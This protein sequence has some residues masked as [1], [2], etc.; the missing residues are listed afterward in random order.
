MLFRSTPSPSPSQTLIPT[1]SSTPTPTLT[2]AASPT[3]SATRTNSPNPNSSNSASPNSSQAARPTPTPTAAD[4]R[5]PRTD[6]RPVRERIHRNSRRQPV[7]RK[8]SHAWLRAGVE[9]IEPGR[10]GGQPAAVASDRR[11]DNRILA[12]AQSEALRA[13]HNLTQDKRELVSRT[14]GLAGRAKVDNPE[15]ANEMLDMLVQQNP[16]D[17]DLRNLVEKGYKP[18]LSKMKAGPE[19]P[20]FLVKTGQQMLTPSQL[21]TT[22]QPSTS[23]TPEGKVVTTQ[24]MPGT[25]QPVKIGRA[26]V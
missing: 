20:D 23:V 24:Q 2:P 18:V 9:R 11:P 25:A 17:Q 16:N 6:G 19:F 8:R 22:F 13:K 3:P 5:V 12:Q 26:H 15:I 10:D 4:R 7:A 1:P 21:Q 14:L